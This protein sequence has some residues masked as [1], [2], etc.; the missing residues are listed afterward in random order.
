MLV[1]S[2]WHTLEGQGPLG[3]NERARAFF[4]TVLSKAD[5]GLMPPAEAFTAIPTAEEGSQP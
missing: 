1:R 5:L 4:L 3:S 2:Q